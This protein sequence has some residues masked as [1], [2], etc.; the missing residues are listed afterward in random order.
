MSM[1]NEELV[2]AIRAGAVERIPELWGRLERLV[3]KRA[4]LMLTEINRPTIEVDDLVQ[5]GFIAFLYAVERY[6]PAGGAK[7]ST[8][9]C[10]CLKNAFSECLGIRTEKQK[11][12]PINGAVSLS[13]PLAKEKDSGTLFDI[14]SDP[15][16]DIPVESVEEKLWREQLHVAI[17]SAMA[18]LSDDQKEMLQ[19][20]YWKGMTL[21]EIANVQGISPERARQKE[22]KVLRTLR[23][24]KHACNLI[25][26]YDFNYYCCTSLDAFNRTG[27]SIQERY[28]IVQE[29]R[30][31]QAEIK[32]K[33]EAEAWNRKLQE[34]DKSILEAKKLL[35]DYR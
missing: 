32:R 13:Y 3:K 12:D 18:A 29:Y 34:V 30:K 4:W 14:V 31:N 26:F 28:L 24:P 15:D 16:A 17:E 10:I 9:L 1:S 11:Q 19:L 2:A 20:R 8:Y 27:M 23:Q 6:D 5:S 22:N 21:H 25:S 7:F 35:R 33:Q